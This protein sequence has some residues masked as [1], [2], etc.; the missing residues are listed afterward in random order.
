MAFDETQIQNMLKAVECKKGAEV[1]IRISL[2]KPQEDNNVQSNAPPPPDNEVTTWLTKLG[3]RSYAT[4]MGDEE[5]DEMKVI[6]ELNEEL[7]E[8]MIKDIGFTSSDAN[9]IRD[10]LHGGE[11]EAKN[12][13]GE[14]TN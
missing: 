2:G 8:K 13:M 9:K 5:Y 6:R 12:K 1:R 7:L 10:N 11:M 3:L 4:K 14:V